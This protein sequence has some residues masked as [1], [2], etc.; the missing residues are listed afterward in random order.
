VRKSPHGHWLQHMEIVTSTNANALKTRV[1]TRHLS[2][3]RP[4]HAAKQ[5]TQIPG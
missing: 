5:Q 3:A 2:Q 4:Y 1:Q